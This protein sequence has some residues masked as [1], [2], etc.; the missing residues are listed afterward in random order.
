MSSDLSALIQDISTEAHAQSKTA[1][2]I[3]ELMQG[4]RDVSVTTSETSKQTAGSVENLAEL[5][6]HLS[7]SVADFKLPP[8]DD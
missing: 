5:V 2:G 1:T 6:I 7:E 8:E 4:I 3:S